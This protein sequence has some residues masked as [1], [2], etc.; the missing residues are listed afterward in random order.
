M[1][2]KR[3]LGGKAPQ[4]GNRVSHSHRATRRKW[5]P[6][7]QRKNLYSLVLDRSVKVTITTQELRTL[8]RCGGLDDYMLKIDTEKLSPSMRRI[9]ALIRERA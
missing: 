3:T 4:A 9:Q 1:S 6:N 5:Y 2:R 8:D 7:I